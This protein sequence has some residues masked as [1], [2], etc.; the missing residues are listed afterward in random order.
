M[1]LACNMRRH[2]DLLV[3]LVNLAVPGAR[4]GQ[5]W[6]GTHGTELV[7]AFTSLLSPAFAERVLAV[8]DAAE[9]LAALAGELH[10][11]LSTSD[12]AR[13]AE[14]T[15]AL[16]RRYGA[17][18]YLTNDV[19]QPYHLHFHGRGATAVEDLGGELVT[20][21]A[22]VVDMVGEDR[23]GLCQA[24]GCDRVY[25]DLTRNGSRR[26]CGSAC[27]ARAKTAAWRRRTTMP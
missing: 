20:A 2:A 22:L 4:G 16:I 24:G 23:F 8:P 11:V 14:R 13:V 19:D 18:P 15:N 27:S 10:A 17:Q 1:D 25:I 7:D 9:R 6:A 5:A 26:Y 12:I 3:E 21:F